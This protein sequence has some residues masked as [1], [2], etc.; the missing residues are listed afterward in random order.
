MAIFA[1]VSSF[2]SRKPM[3]KKYSEDMSPLLDVSARTCRHLRF[4]KALFEI[5]DPELEGALA[6]VLERL[7]LVDRT[8]GE[9]AP[10]LSASRTRRRRKLTQAL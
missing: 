2:G 6:V 1:F 9:S 5:D 8:S 7:A 4:M 10:P 3:T